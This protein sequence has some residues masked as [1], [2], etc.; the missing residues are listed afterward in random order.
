MARRRGYGQIAEA[1]TG[2]GEKELRISCKLGG[3]NSVVAG[4]RINVL[5]TTRK[6]FTEGLHY[7]LDAAARNMRHYGGV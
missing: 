5:A 7:I 3:H 4:S 6:S 1:T 2:T